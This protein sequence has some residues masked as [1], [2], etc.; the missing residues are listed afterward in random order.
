MYVR[1]K[2]PSHIYIHPIPSRIHNASFHI[3][4]GGRSRRNQDSVFSPTCEKSAGKG[5]SVCFGEKEMVSQK[6][7]SYMHVTL[8]QTY[9]T[10]YKGDR[11]ERNSSF[12]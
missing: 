6:S 5:L 3:R 1:K 8:P 9:I 11:Q 4:V 12:R 2:N 10:I 7:S